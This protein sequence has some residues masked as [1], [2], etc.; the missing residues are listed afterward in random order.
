MRVDA[1][2]GVSFAVAA[3]ECV[4]IVG[5][6]GSG[7]TT[8]LAML[9]GLLTPSSGSIDLGGRDLSRLAKPDLARVRRE[10]VGFIFQAGNLVPYLTARENI[11]LIGAISHKRH[12]K[13]RADRLI[14]GLGLSHRANAVAT[15]LSGGERQRVAIA[16]ALANEPDVL[17][18]DEPTANL[19]LVRGSQVVRALIKEVR[20]REIAAIIV[21]HDREMARLTDRILDMR[22][23]LLHDVKDPVEA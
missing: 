17:L 15:E 10:S 12:V 18:A 19:D 3:G 11:E 8:L 20:R 22:D 4:A 7:K 14:A 9:G 1:V 2:R 23:G 6:S 13:Q 5:P 21:T 16:R